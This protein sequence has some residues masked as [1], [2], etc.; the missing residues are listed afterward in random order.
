MYPSNHHSIQTAII[1]GATSGLGYATALALARLDWHVIL[2]GR[3]DIK[4][5]AALD[6]IRTEYPAAIIEYQSLD[7]ANLKSITHF[8]QQLQQKNLAINLLINNAGVMAPPQRQLTEDGFELQ[9]GSNY[10]GHFALTAHLLPLLHRTGDAKVVSVSSI[11]HKRGKIQLA[12]LQSQHR[13]RPMTAYAQSKLALLMFALE[14]HRRSQAQGWHIQSLAAHPGIA[15][16]PLF[17]SGPGEHGVFNRLTQYILPWISQSAA[18]GALPIIQA[19]LD[20]QIVSGQYL[21]PQG[22][23]EI[24]GRPGFAQISS[25][26]L[27]SKTAAQL[28]EL[29]V[30]LTGAQWPTA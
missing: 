21:G 22:F 26:A 18:N 30:Q 5:Q 17:V 20:P 2:T 13:Y 23:L 24:K 7:L 15:A 16:T 8:A 27:D 12:D 25:Q 6:S 9:I 3:N 10:L 19:A 28:W 14:L 11:A 29:S 1:T 4:G